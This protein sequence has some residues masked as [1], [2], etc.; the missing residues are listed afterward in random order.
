MSTKDPIANIGYDSY[1]PTPEGWPRS[2]Q[3]PI[4]RGPRLCPRCQTNWMPRQKGLCILCL[5]EVVES[6]QKEQM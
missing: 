5:A 4:V 6:Y 3:K 2:P 1:P